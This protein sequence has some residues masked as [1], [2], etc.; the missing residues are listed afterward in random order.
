MPQKILLEIAAN[1]V[2]SALIAQYGGADRIEFFSN[3]AEGGV[4]PSYGSLKLVREKIKIPVYVM[5]RPRGGDFNYTEL[6]FEEMVHDLALIR[7]LGFE[8]VVFGILTPQGTL[9]IARNKTLVELAK[10]MKCT[11]HRAFDRVVDAKQALEDAISCGFERIL[12]SGC[13]ATALNGA[14]TIK[15]LVTLANGRIALLGGSGVNSGNVA[16][17]IQQTGLSEVHSTAK[18]ILPSLMEYHNPALQ[19]G[20]QELAQYSCDLNEVKAIKAALLAL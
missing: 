20:A 1:S 19:N 11:L 4:T 13:E 12:S 2:Q 15:T 14:T 8:G 10:P 5:L 9:D 18:A 3:L 7:N 6:E 17:L 16:D